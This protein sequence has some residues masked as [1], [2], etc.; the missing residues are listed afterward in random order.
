MLDYIIKTNINKVSVLFLAIITSSCAITDSMLAPDNTNAVYSFKG[1][2]QGI[3]SVIGDQTYPAFLNEAD[4]QAKL[5]EHEFG[6][7]LV[8]TR[9]ND[10][11]DRVRENFQLEN[12]E[13]R[14]IDTQF[15]WFKNHPEYIN[16]VAARA[17]PYMHFIVETL[18]A[19][20]IPGELALLP[21]VE[22]AFKPFAYSHGRAS[23]IWQFIPSTGRLYG[24]KQNWWYDGRRDIYA[25]TNASLRLLKNLATHFNGDWL[26]ALA[27]YNSGQGTVQRAIR[28]NKKLGRPTDFF[29]LKLP[30]ETKAYVPKLLA[31]KKLIMDPELY[32]LTLLPIVDEPYFKKIDISSQIDLALAAEMAG[33]TIEELYNLNPGF[34]R[35]ATAPKGP[36]YLLIPKDKSDDFEFTL[37]D[38]P[39]KER[40]KWIRHRIRKGETIGSI[41]RKYHISTSLIKKTNNMRGNRIREGHNL[42]IPTASKRLSSYKLSSTQ[43]VKQNQNIKRKGRKINYTIQRGDTWWGLATRHGVGTRQ[44]AKWNGLAPRDKLKPGQKIVIWARKT[45]NNSNYRPVTRPPNRTQRIGYRV[46]RGDSLSRISKKFRVSIKQIRRW[47][48]KLSRSKY[49]QP[50]QRI[51]LYVDVTRQS[52]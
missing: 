44:L 45:T 32:N 13:N 15:K 21:I 42:L 41:A 34:N 3:Y 46:R 37:A 25:S 38:L 2:A 19:K 8:D 31:L 1:E 39:I 12:I 10:L 47:N 30:P 43:R 14:R 4:L 35:W 11:W 52:G 23:G 9:A 18:E 22:S 24:L 16:R 7:L 27:A 29:S 49:L 40:I 51:T 28:K 48:R 26:L 36:H 5:D 50:G 33:I 17:T 20:G 6:H